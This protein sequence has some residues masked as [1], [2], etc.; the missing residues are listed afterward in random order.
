VPNARVLILGAPAPSTVVPEISP[1]LDQV[2]LHSFSRDPAKRYET[3]IHEAEDPVELVIKMAKLPAPRIRY[4]APDVSAPF[5][6]VIDRALEF[7]RDDRYESATAI[8]SALI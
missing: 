6:R 2:V 4:V 5:A 3:R 7:Q 8:R 1:G